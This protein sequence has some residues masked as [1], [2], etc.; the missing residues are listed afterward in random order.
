MSKRGLSV[1]LPV[2]QH[3]YW[4]HIV[5]TLSDYSGPATAAAQ[6]VVPRLCGEPRGR[7]TGRNKFRQFPSPSPAPAS[8]AGIETQMCSLLDF[9]IGPLLIK[10]TSDPNE[11]SGNASLVVRTPNVMLIDQE[12][13]IS[14][15]SQ[16][17][18]LV[19]QG[20]PAPL[21]QIIFQFATHQ[22]QPLTL[23][24][25]EEEPRQ[26]AGAGTGEG[27]A[28]R[29]LGVKHDNLFSSQTAPNIMCSYSG[30]LPWAGRRTGG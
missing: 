8:A 29:V 9:G 13:I 27:G 25:M 11:Q 3:R 2:C 6:C 28:N 17:A 5:S 15:V 18:G 7:L 19:P 24:G 26:A 22:G 12:K 1:L 10:A 4:P 23:L 14:G 20:G 16:N 30:R 21:I